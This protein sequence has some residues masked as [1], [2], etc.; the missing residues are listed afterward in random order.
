M[1]RTALPITLTQEER[2]QLLSYTRTRTMQAQI[3]DRARMLLYKAD[4]MANQVIADHLDVDIKTVVLLSLIHIDVYKRQL[5]FLL[6]GL[7]PDPG[8]L[9]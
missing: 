1:G 9:P 5:L 8:S 6:Q 4:G 3:V 7:S 2:L